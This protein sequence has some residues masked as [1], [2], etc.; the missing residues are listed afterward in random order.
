MPTQTAKSRH[1]R[2]QS[3]AIFKAA[4]RAHG[5]TIMPREAGDYGYQKM[6][7][8]QLFP[9]QLCLGEKG[10][11]VD[12]IA[13]YIQSVGWELIKIRSSRR[14]SPMIE[15][16]PPSPQAS[17]LFKGCARCGQR[18][19]VHRA[20]VPPILAPQK[21]A[22]RAS[23]GSPG[24]EWARRAP[25]MLMMRA[26]AVRIIKS[27][28]RA[29]AASSNLLP[30]HRAVQKHAPTPHGMRARFAAIHQLISSFRIRAGDPARARI[31]SISG[32]PATRR[33]GVGGN[34]VFFIK[35]SP[36]QLRQAPAAQ[37][38]GHRTGTLAARFKG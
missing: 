18:E 25:L 3:T 37:S 30:L 14:T 11:L 7:K 4:P 15:A 21:P 38:R 26:P 16:S 31:T 17:I 1:T 9:S 6:Q 36:L 33:S 24:L 22:S 2:T 20:V 23:A 27:R 10:S 28:P 12:M 13:M 35:A 19:F 5:L 8:S 32:T 29:E 34:G